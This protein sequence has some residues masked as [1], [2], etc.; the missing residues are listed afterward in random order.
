MVAAASPPLYPADPLLALRNC[1]S[2]DSLYRPDAAI[3]NDIVM[4]GVMPAQLAAAMTGCFV[5]TQWAH[6]KRRYVTVL[7]ALQCVLSVVTVGA[8]LYYRFSEDTGTD[9][10]HIALDR[11]QYADH[12]LGF[13]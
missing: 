13:L 1:R 10:C 9:S 2:A 4:G 12:C 7:V 5:L 11:P 8:E 6:Q 3:Y